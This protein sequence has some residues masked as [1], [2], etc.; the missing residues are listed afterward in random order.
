MRPLFGV[1]CAFVLLG[2]VL[3]HPIC[4]QPIWQESFD[5]ET[6]SIGS[7]I[8]RHPLVV[9]AHGMG[10]DGSDAIKVIYRGYERGSRRVTVRSPLPEPATAYTLSFAVKFCE[11]F[12]FARGGKLHGLGPK[13][14]VTGGKPVTPDGWSAR[15]MFRRGGGLMTY[16]YHQ[17][18]PGKFAQAKVAP[19]F[20][21][22]PGRYYRIDMRVTLNEPARAANG[23]MEVWVDRQK[24]IEHAGLRLRAAEGAGG[25]VQTLLFSTFHGGNSPAW[26]PRTADG[27][28]K[29]DCAYFDDWAVTK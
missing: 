15:L 6:T 26:A 29:I 9:L 28:Y 3:A 23:K 21:F 12:D 8:V 2:S 27:D 22:V 14:P 17:D 10:T 16:V 11:G 1:Q 20:S 5:G 13:K 24:L 18:L 25:L 7:A 19:N 4:A